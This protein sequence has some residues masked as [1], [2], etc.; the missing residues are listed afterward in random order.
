[1]TTENNNTEQ[2]EV[3]QTQPVT[4]RYQQPSDFHADHLHLFGQLE[5]D[6][7]AFDAEV[8]EPIAFR[9]AMATLFAIVSSDYRY[10]PKDRTAY[11][12]FVQMRRNYSNQGLAKAYRAYYDWLWKNDPQAWLILDPVIS[13]HPDKISL[14]VFSKDEGSYALLSFDHDFFKASGD[15]TFGTTSI[16][17][18]SDLA[19]GIE[20]MRSFRSNRFSVGQQAVEF[21]AETATDLDDAEVIEKQIQVPKSW[22]RGFLQVQ[23][24]SQLT[25]DTFHIKPIDLYNCLHHLRMHADVKGKRRGLRI[26][27]VPHEQ[28]RLVLEPDDTVITGSAG[29]YEG[30]Q[31]KVIRLWGRR[32]LT[33]LKRFLPFA[34]DIEV[35][36]LGNG[37]PAFW[38]LK[39]KGMSLTLAVTGF[40]ASNWSQAL[41]FDLLLPRQADSLETLESVTTHLK[42]VYSADL[43]AITKQTGLSRKDCSAALQQACQQGLVI[44]DVANEVYR[45]RPLTHEP[46]DMD[47]FRY[48]QPAEALA[49]DLVSRQ[50]AVGPLSITMIP[51]D[52]TEISADITVKED[53][54]D[55]LTRLKLNEEG[56]V[57]KAECSCHQIMQHGLSQGP[58]SHLIALRLEYAAQQANQDIS[59][60]TQETRLFT[61]R[62]KAAQELIQ[63]TL[64]NKR[65]VVNRDMDTTPR[66]QQFAFNSVDDARQAYLGQISQLELSGFIEG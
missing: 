51:N 9:E 14:E 41:N 65:L 60:I 15:T 6:A 49:Y 53:K 20:Q 59:G 62:K 21:K 43:A 37:M 13:V 2:T 61:R 24:S 19:Q 46:L 5:R 38:I 35:R 7:V 16:D 34:D 18:S 31:A 23:S 1:M 30:K 27:L 8:S 28:P 57:A 42:A 63:V 52:G 10:V 44:Y 11:A 17:F 36:L 58:C 66:Q 48:R 47:E 64:N 4:L 55:Y 32:R 56:H 3:K 33:L 50:K 40:T 25:A 26:E 54:R 39:G 45:Y 22:V 12:A 29:V